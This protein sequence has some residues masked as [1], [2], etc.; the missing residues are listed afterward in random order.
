MK[1]TNRVENNENVTTLIFIRLFQG[2]QVDIT[3]SGHGGR[4][5]RNGREAQSNRRVAPILISAASVYYDGPH[6][7]SA[8]AETT[9]TAVASADTT[10][11]NNGSNS[12]PNRT[13]SLALARRADDSRL[14][15][16]AR[17]L[18][19][20][21]PAYNRGRTD[22]PAQ[23]KLARHHVH[24]QLRA[25]DSRAHRRRRHLHTGVVDSNGAGVIQADTASSPS[26]RRHRFG[27]IFARRG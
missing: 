21:L 9:A 6:L 27:H 1:L 20:G 25:A 23:A 15:D 22:E 3:D 24:C 14:P 10:D 4:S 2:R 8:G 18:D 26:G 13:D 17:D 7:R 12:D 11:S 5:Y 19:P 16:A